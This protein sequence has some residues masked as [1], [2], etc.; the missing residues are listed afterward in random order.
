MITSEASYTALNYTYGEEQDV[1]SVRSWRTAC[2]PLNG[3][4]GLMYTLAA[5]Y[6]SALD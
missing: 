6:P 4:L 1:I 5:A 3:R 2:C